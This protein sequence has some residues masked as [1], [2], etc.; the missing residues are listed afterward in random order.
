MPN[1]RTYDGPPT[2]LNPSSGGSAAWSQAG[3]RAGAFY[4][5]AA[6]FAREAGRLAADNKAQ[7]WPFDILE[8][9][10][11]Q[12]EAAARAA[13]GQSGGGGGGVRARA[14]RRDPFAM[15]ASYGP[16]FYSPHNDSAI[17]A[18]A[19][20][21]QGAAALGQAL[22]DGGYAVSSRSPS[23]RTARNGVPPVGSAA[24]SSLMREALAYAR[25]LEGRG[26]PAYTLDQGEFVPADGSALARYQQARDK[27]VKRWTQEGIDTRDYWTRYYGGDPAQT[28]QSSTPSREQGGSY[29]TGGGGSYQGNQQGAGSNAWGPNPPAGYEPPGFWSNLFSGWGSG[30]GSSDA[31]GFGEDNYNVY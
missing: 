28:D 27:D 17:D 15:G 14:S 22:S 1:I 6:G 5:D 4:G 24:R 26:E 9:Y 13:A 25:Q 10:Q 3:R 8:L 2:N 23:S 16:G 30:G 19:Q 31:G 29:G 21:S 20:I 12:S 18:N 11:R 7:L